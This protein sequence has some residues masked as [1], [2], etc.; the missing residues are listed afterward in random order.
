MAGLHLS[1][2]LVLPLLNARQ[3]SFLSVRHKTKYPPRYTTNDLLLPNITPAHL[4]SWNPPK[5]D[6]LYT[7][8]NSLLLETAQSEKYNTKHIQTSPFSATLLS[9]G[10][11]SELERLL[12]CDLASQHAPSWPLKSAQATTRLTCAACKSEAK[13][14]L[15]HSETQNI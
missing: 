5:P 11:L 4:S 1:K 8:H 10:T 12:L 2:L 7:V 14:D 3:H 9:A 13:K 15:L 6:I